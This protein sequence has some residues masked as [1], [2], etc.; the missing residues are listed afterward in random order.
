MTSG[1]PFIREL[2]CLWTA[3]GRTP[4]WVTGQGKRG[5]AGVNVGRDAYATKPPFCPMYGYPTRFL[6][7]T[8]EGALHE[9][10][11]KLSRLPAAEM[12][13]ASHMWMNC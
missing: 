9:R 7:S 2:N 5:T 1:P 8:S 3:A 4:L 11:R 13:N 6:T 10:I 12:V